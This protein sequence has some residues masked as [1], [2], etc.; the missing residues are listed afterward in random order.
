MRGARWVDI[1]PRIALEAA[2]EQTKISVICGL[3]SQQVMNLLI[4][5][6]VVLGKH[7]LNLLKIPVRDAGRDVLNFFRRA[8][9]MPVEAI[10]TG[11]AE[12]VTIV[13]AF[14][15][16]DWARVGRSG[17]LRRLISGFAL[18][19]NSNTAVATLSLASS[20]WAYPGGRGMQLLRLQM[21]LHMLI[22]LPAGP[23]RL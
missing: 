10:W 14:T 23:P 5:R 1:E 12:S 7:T 16:Q 4:I 17:C 19:G 6:Y 3:L 18:I 20:R 22:N 8:A 21:L 15:V 13:I 11:D 2:A 9:H